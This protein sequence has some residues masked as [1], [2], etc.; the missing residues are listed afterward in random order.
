[1]AG[2]IAS[3][4]ILYTNLH[5]QIHHITLQTVGNSQGCF[6]CTQ[7]QTDCNQY[8]GC[9]NDGEVYG[10]Y[11]DG[12]YSPYANGTSVD[13]STR[14]LPHPFGFEDVYPYG[15]ARCGYFARIYGFKYFGTQGGDKCWAGNSYAQATVGS[16]SSLRCEVL[17]L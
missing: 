8:L 4:C 1:V 12:T 6:A 13:V 3:T 17:D 16:V 5:I 7:R 11:A 9:Y 10:P 15:A 14:T 2:S